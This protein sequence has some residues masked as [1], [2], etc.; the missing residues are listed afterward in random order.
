MLPQ[1]NLNPLTK[2]MDTNKQFAAIRNQISQLRDEVDQALMSIGYENLTADLRRRIDG[3]ETE[4]TGSNQL[5]N[6]VAETIKAKYITA[7]MISAHY[8]SIGDLQAVTARI[9]SI[10]S[11]YVKTQQLNAVSGRIDNLTSI[12]ITTQN[13]SAQSINA[14]QINAGKIQASQINMDGLA[15]AL[16]AQDV[17]CLTIT[18]GYG[19]LESA[20]IHSLN[21]SSAVI[22]GKS[23][24]WFYDSNYGRY[25]LS[26]S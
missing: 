13:F 24:S 21:A 17:T 2:D 1:V 16:S 10:E 11:D 8:A 5:S 12:A 18:S 19:D 26:G 14:N 20:D 3:L 6:I 23:V 4:I 15:S 7:D 9:G 25:F 22:G